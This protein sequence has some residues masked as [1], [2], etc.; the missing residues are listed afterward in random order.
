MGRTRC[1]RVLARDAIDLSSRFGMA[2]FPA[3]VAQTGRV[4]W[5]V[6]FNSSSASPRIH[7]R[8][9]AMTLRTLRV[10]NSRVEP[11]FENGG[12]AILMSAAT[13]LP[14]C[15]ISLDLPCKS[16]RAE[17]GRNPAICG[18]P[19]YVELAPLAVGDLDGVVV[20]GA[21]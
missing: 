21:A 17:R 18:A 5:T 16:G 4:T 3:L 7:A 14:S 15:S 1:D 20:A 10:P 19:D 8:N 11:I 2:A 6:P 12:S 13:F 9:P